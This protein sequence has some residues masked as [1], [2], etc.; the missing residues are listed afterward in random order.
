[1]DG[2]CG[3]SGERA[4]ARAEGVKRLDTDML[5]MLLVDVESFA[6]QIQRR[7]S[8]PATLSHAVTPAPQT[9]H[10]GVSGATGA[11]VPS[12]AG[13]ESIGVTAHSQNLQH[14]GVKCL[15]AAVL[16]SK[17]ARNNQTAEALTANSILGVTG[18]TVPAHVKALLIVSEQSKHL[19]TREAITVKGL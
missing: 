13:W 7:R 3:V 6:I 2:A 10:C 4:L 5:Q 9:M 16:T 19:V 8:S 15:L 14:V 12:L 18:Q 1:M 17:T 11:I